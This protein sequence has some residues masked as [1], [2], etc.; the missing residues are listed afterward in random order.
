MRGFIELRSGVV[1][2]WSLLVLQS[3][4]YSSRVI[5]EMTGKRDKSGTPKAWR[6]VP[7]LVNGGLRSL[8]QFRAYSLSQP[9]FVPKDFS[10]L[11]ILYD[12]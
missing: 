1:I 12:P 5:N 9:D 4:L 8:N 10:Q 6:V 3:G 2:N 7:G 11:C